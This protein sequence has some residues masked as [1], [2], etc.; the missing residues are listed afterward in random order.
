VPPWR[1]NVAACLS[2]TAREQVDPR[3]EY[4]AR[5]SSARWRPPC[6]KRAT[7]TKRSMAVS[8]LSR[9]PGYSC[10]TARSRG[11]DAH[12]RCRHRDRAGGR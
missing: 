3:A 6:F 10:K 12:W 11:D 5:S 1:R 7:R 2:S 4:S 9:L 8:L